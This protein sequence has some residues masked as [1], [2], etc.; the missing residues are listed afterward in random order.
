MIF[1]AFLDTGGYTESCAARYNAQLLRFGAG[2]G[3]RPRAHERS[4]LKDIAALPRAAAPAA[5][6][7]SSAEPGDASGQGDESRHCRGTRSSAA[8]ARRAGRAC[9]WRW[10][11]K[12]VSLTI[13]ARTGTTQERPRDHRRY[14]HSRD[15]SRRRHHTARASAPS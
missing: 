7:A 2:P 15:A 14:R 10:P 8:P 12:G 6:V 4:K 11:A 1:V 5:A 9:R 13:V 3:D